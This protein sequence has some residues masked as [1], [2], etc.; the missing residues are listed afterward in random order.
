MG[1]NV[2]WIIIGFI[3]IGI[4]IF[5]FYLL[6]GCTSSAARSQAGNA[7]LYIFTAIPAVLAIALVLGIV[8]GTVFLLLQ[9]SGAYHRQVTRDTIEL[10]EVVMENT[11]SIPPI[12]IKLNKDA[13]ITSPKNKL[14]STNNLALPKKIKYYGTETLSNELNPIFLQPGLPSIDN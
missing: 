5:G 13:S 6:W 11:P 4:S 7:L 10:V 1:K 9:V 12:S 14:R 3:A 2:I 8:S